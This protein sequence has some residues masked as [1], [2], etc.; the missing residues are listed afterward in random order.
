M[1]LSLAIPVIAFSSFARPLYAQFTDP[2]TYTPGP[3]G[4]NNIEFDYTYARQNA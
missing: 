1:R 2:R 4:V 3:V